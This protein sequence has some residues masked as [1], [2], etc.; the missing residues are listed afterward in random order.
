MDSKRGVLVIVTG[1]FYTRCGL[2]VADSVV[3]FNSGLPITIFTDQTVVDPVF[4]SVGLIQNPPL[5]SKVDYRNK[6]PFEQILNLDSDIRVVDKLDAL[7]RLLKRF[8]LAAACVR[9]RFSLKNQ[10]IWGQFQ[11]GILYFMQRIR[12]WID[13]EKKFGDV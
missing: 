12:S 10:K 5:R 13:S 7:F 9:Y 8:E 2:T 1:E 6:S 11:I 4:M 3:R